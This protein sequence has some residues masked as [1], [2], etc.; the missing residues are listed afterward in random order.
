VD[1]FIDKL[2]RVYESMKQGD[3]TFAEFTD[4]VKKDEILKAYEAL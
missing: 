3:E 2:L 4:R 1:V